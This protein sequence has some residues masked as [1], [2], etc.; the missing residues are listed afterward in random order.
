M[1]FH[2]VC[3][4]PS[5]RSIIGVALLLVSA[6]LFVAAPRA[7]TL[8]VITATDRVAG[9]LAIDG[10]VYK[11]DSFSDVKQADASG[12]EEVAAWFSLN[13]GDWVIYEAQNGRIRRLHRQPAD[14]LD[15]PPGHP[16]EA[17]SVVPMER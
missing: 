14:S 16:I 10:E 8:G 11:V 4:N 12:N 3:T 5:N 9:T 2:A 6:L 1:T 13:V 7:A 15:R 17:G